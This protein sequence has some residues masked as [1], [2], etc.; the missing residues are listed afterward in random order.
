MAL[1]NGIREALAL[2]GEAR[3]AHIKRAKEHVHA[4]FSLDAM[5]QATLAVYRQL[6]P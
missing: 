1:C 6:V 2:E 4:R 3:D 5:C